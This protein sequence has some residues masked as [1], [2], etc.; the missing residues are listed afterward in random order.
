ME[1][2]LL[3]ESLRAL[4]TLEPNRGAMVGF[5][6]YFVISATVNHLLGRHRVELRETREMMK[7]YPGEAWPR[8][9]EIV[10]LAA[11]AR[12]A[13]VLERLQ[14]YAAEDPHRLDVA[15]DDPA[16]CGRAGPRA[17]R[18]HGSPVA[19]RCGDRSGPADA[20]SP[21]AVAR[22][23][24]DELRVHG[25]PEAAGRLLEWALAWWEGQPLSIRGAGV[26][27]RE[28]VEVLRRSGALPEATAAVHAL[29]QADPRD[30]ELMGLEAVIAVAAGGGERVNLLADSLSELQTPHLFGA[31]EMALARVE[32]TRGSRD[33]AISYLLRARSQGFPLG[34]HVHQ[35]PDFSTLRT[36]PEFL[37]LTEP[38]REN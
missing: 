33:A 19:T 6:P 32:A 5:L 35:E 25:R 18:V 7:L 23:A 26:I 30:V 36:D 38:W 20:L 3:A 17:P 22:Q 8:A 28:R 10:A 24:S 11:L 37:R 27:E 15:V 14:S 1:Q 34:F 21:L 29:R 2:G 16:G 12:E 31:A 13:A 9:L 4:E